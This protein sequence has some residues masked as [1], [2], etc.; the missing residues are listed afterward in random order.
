[1]SGA[2]LAG[3]H[4][5]VTGAARGIGAAIAQA[6]AGAGARVSLLGR[7]EEKLQRA[8]AAIRDA[9]PQSETAAFGADVSDSAAVTHAIGRARAHFGAV[10]LL[11]NNAGQAGSAPFLKTDEALWQRML[12]VNLTGTY[13]CARAVL[14]DMLQGSF[15]RIVNIASTAGLRGYAY[16]VAYTASK[17]GVV[18]LTRAL[19]LEIAASGVTVNAICPGYTDTDIVRDAIGTIVNQTGRSAEEARALLVRSNPQ[20]R[21]IEPEEIAQAALWLCGA[22]TASITGQCLTI[23]GG[24]VMV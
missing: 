12:A 19:A 5:V 17:H 8:A 2:Q 7:D 24:E 13:L 4:A 1:M 22:H 3:R 21:L 11:I 18:G 20:R 23:A 6:L 15:G 9:C 10:Q 14:P 16:V